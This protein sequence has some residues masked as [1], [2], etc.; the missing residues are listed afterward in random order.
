MLSRSRQFGTSLI[1]PKCLGSEVSYVRSV[2][3]PPVTKSFKDDVPVFTNQLHLIICPNHNIHQLIH[4]L[5]QKI[6]GCAKFLFYHEITVTSFGSF[7]R[8]VITEKLENLKIWPSLPSPRQLRSQ[9]SDA[10]LDRADS[11]TSALLN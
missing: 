5:M 7:R 2:L 9:T 3:T 4:I 1:V 6:E 8:G 11:E 10:H